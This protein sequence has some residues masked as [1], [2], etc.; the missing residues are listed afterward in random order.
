MLRILAQFIGVFHAY[1]VGFYLAGLKLLYSVLPAFLTGENS[2]DTIS[3]RPAPNQ[4]SRQPNTSAICD[5][6]SSKIQLPHLT[7]DWEVM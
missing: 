7:D 3:V 1:E 5:M 6:I 2:R 4:M